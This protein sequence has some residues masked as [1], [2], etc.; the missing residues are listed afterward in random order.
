MR[1]RI[2]LTAFLMAVVIG[3]V[4]AF[5]VSRGSGGDAANSGPASTPS[6]VGSAPTDSAPTGTGFSDPI[7]DRYGRKVA[8]PNNPAGQPLPQHDPAARRVECG[9]GAAV[10]SPE[11]VMIQRSYGMPIL[12]SQTDGPTH[13]EGTVLTGYRH[14]LQGAVLAGW[15]WVA[16]SYVGGVPTRETITQLTILPAADRSR[17]AQA[18]LSMPNGADRFRAVVVA[19]DAFRVLSCDSEFVAAEW[20]L[21]L[22]IDGTGA[23]TS[24]PRWVGIRLNL[25]WRDGD[26]KVQTS[27][28]PI[29]VGPGQRYTSIDGWTRWTQ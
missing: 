13:L 14:S 7:S 28:Q 21:R 22:D 25:L 27:S 1:T 17:I 2:L 23:A 11:Q 29:T 18:P 6:A 20:A 5:I 19:P 8:V 4:A 16:R 24:S 26:W 10:S 3:V 15:N 12:M 9:S